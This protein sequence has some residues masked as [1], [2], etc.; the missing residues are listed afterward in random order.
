MH[1]RD[2]FKFFKRSHQHGRAI[3]AVMQTMSEPAAPLWFQFHVSSN[4][5][6]AFFQDRLG[7][8]LKTVDKTGHSM[9]IMIAPTFPLR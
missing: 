4:E 3:P 7:K 6:A 2:C 9:S 1:A 5:S 8:P